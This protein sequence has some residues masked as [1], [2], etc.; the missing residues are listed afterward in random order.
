MS[1]TKKDQIGW[2]WLRTKEFHN[3][4]VLPKKT[5]VLMLSQI[6]KRQTFLSEGF[7]IF[8]GKRNTII[9]NKKF[10]NGCCNHD[11]CVALRSKE[12]GKKEVSEET[13]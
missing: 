8:K 11:I 5:E 12:E 6:L 1:H 3:G 2:R 9:R 13:V 4:K 7:V 10:L